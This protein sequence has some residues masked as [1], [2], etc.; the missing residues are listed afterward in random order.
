MNNTVTPSFAYDGGEAYEAAQLLVSPLRVLLEDELEAVIDLIAA[1]PPA[2]T[3]QAVRSI[4]V[5]SLICTLSAMLTRWSGT[6]GTGE[7]SEIMSLAAKYLDSNQIMPPEESEWKQ[8]WYIAM[9]PDAMEDWADDV[10]DLWNQLTL[11]TSTEYNIAAPPSLLGP[12][13]GTGYRHALAAVLRK[14]IQA[15]TDISAPSGGDVTNTGTGAGNVGTGDLPP[16]G[17]GY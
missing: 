15:Y 1:N 14:N 11:K 3:K 9:L 4:E 13:Q 16:G 17:E 10:Q 5:P 7:A 12:N 6:A 8:E 2:K